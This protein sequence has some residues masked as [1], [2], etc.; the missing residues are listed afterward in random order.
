MALGA[1]GG[2]EV[3]LGIFHSPHNLTAKFVSPGG[4][5]TPRCIKA[6]E[7]NMHMIEFGLGAIKVCQICTSSVAWKY[8]FEVGVD[9]VGSRSR[10]KSL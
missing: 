6:A 5:P 10:F 8:S 7:M 2:S 3:I 1:C 9:G 4:Q